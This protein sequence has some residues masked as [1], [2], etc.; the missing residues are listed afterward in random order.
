ME[1]KLE[2]P[3]PKTNY[4]VSPG[5]NVTRLIHKCHAKSFYVSTDHGGSSPP[6]QNLIQVE[7]VDEWMLWAYLTH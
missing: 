1:M 4:Q 2:E 3:F 5:L 6:G 7:K